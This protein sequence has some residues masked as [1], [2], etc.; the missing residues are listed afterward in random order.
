MSRRR[1]IETRTGQKVTLTGMGVT[2]ILCGVAGAWL[3]DHHPEL[4]ESES[5]GETLTTCSE[6]AEL[7]CYDDFGDVVMFDRSD[8]PIGAEVYEDGSWVSPDGTTGC[9]DGG[10]CQD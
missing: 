3:G 1:F 9:L 4:F 7:P 10:L 8:V 5:H 6:G 2:L